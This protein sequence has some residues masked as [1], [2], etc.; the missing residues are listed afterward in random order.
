MKGDLGESKTRERFIL[1]ELSGFDL[2]E[3]MNL[4]QMITAYKPIL[5]NREH[6][7]NDS[8]V[9]CGEDAAILMSIPGFCIKITMAVPAYAGDMRRFVNPVQLVNYIGFSP[10]LDASGEIE[11]RI[12]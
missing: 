4:H 5:E 1:E 8:L 11:K 2:V 12:P 6:Q 9:A 3:A 7:I 10:R